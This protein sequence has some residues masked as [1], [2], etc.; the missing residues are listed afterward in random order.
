MGYLIKVKCTI[1]WSPFYVACGNKVSPFNVYPPFTYVSYKGELVR[2]FTTPEEYSSYLARAFSISFNLMELLTSVVSEVFPKFEYEF[3]RMDWA[4]GDISKEEVVVEFKGALLDAVLNAETSEA[5]KY[6]LARLISLM[7]ITTNKYYLHHVAFDPWIKVNL[8]A[9]SEFAALPHAVDA[10]KREGLINVSEKSPMHVVVVGADVLFLPAYEPGR[11]SL[12]NDLLSFIRKVGIRVY[13]QSNII[14]VNPRNRA[15][16]IIPLDDVDVVI[17]KH[18]RI[19]VIVGPTGSGKTKKALGMIGDVLSDIR[20]NMAWDIRRGAMVVI[21]GRNL[22]YDIELV[23]SRFKNLVVLRGHPRISPRDYAYLAIP[24]S[25]EEAEVV[26][27][28]MAN[29]LAKSQ[30]LQDALRRTLNDVQVDEVIKEVKNVKA[31][32][33]VVAAALRK[34]NLLTKYNE[35]AKLGALRDA[36]INYHGVDLVAH[37]IAPDDAYKEYAAATVLRS[38]TFKRNALYTIYLIDDADKTLLG[39]AS[40][41]MRQRAMHLHPLLA[42][43]YDIDAVV[44]LTMHEENIAQIFPN[45]TRPGLLTAANIYMGF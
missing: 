11:S 27:V 33:E 13:M 8:G 28:A 7:E 31:H 44:I 6:A 22:D 43:L 39:D 10:L 38:I 30:D 4:L 36:P 17:T 35:A 42:R 32:S 25:P 41:S 12:L 19:R 26:E 34:L 16:S 23:K 5:S 20:R 40:L 14:L 2:M 3:R 37:Y 15:A 24:M 21:V 9:F 1:P 45:V 18:H 29:A